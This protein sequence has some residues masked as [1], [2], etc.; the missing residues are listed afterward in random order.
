MD[1]RLSDDNVT[2]LSD[3]INGTGDGL[4]AD[5]YNNRDFTDFELARTDATVDFDWG[6]GSPDA[7]IDADTFSVRWTGQIEPRFSETYTFE[8]RSDDGVRLWVNN[9]LIIERY[10]DQAP[11]RHTGTITLEAGQRYDIRLDY[12]ENGGGATSELR[13]SS[14]SQASEIIP[15]SQLYSAAVTTPD[16]PVEPNPPMVGTGDGLR[17]DYYNNRDFTDLELTRTDATVDFDWGRGSPDA[18]IAADTYSIRWTGQVEPQFSETYTFQTSSDDGVRLWVNDKLIID[19]FVDQPSTA[20]RGTIAL[21]AGQRYDIRL[22]YYENYG[23]ASA[24][25]RWSSASQPLEIIPQSQLYSSAVT[26]P[27]PPIDPEPPAGSESISIGDPD[28][29]PVDTDVPGIEINHVYTVSENVIALRIETG[30]VARGRQV[31]YVSEAGDFIRDDGWI[32][33]DNEAIG[34]QV[35]GAPDKIRLVD[36]YVGSKLDTAWADNINNYQIVAADGSTITPTNV[37]RKSKIDDMAHTGVWEFEWPMDHIVYLELPNDL[38][39]GETYQ[40]NFGGDILEDA[41]FVYDPEITRSDAVHVSH[42]GFDPDDSAKVAFLSTWMG[43]GGGLDYDAGTPFWLIDVATGERVYEGQTTLSKAA[44]EAEDFRG[45]N[46]SQTDVFMMD[47]SDFGTPGQYAVYV[48]GVGTSYEFEIGENTWRDAFYISARGMYHQRSGIE[49]EQ[50][51]TDYARPRPFHPEDGVVIYQ[52]NVALMDTSMGLNGGVDVFEALQANRT[53]EIVTDAW[54]G[55]MDAGDWDRR[56]Q[57][58]DVSRSF[59]ELVELHGDY[60]DS[61]NLNIPES[62][63]DLPDILDEALWG[64]DVFRRL[65][66]EEGGIPGGIESAGHPIWFEGSWQESQDIMVYAPGIWSSYFYSGVAARAAHVLTDYDPALAQTYQES[67]LRAMNWANAELSKQPNDRYNEIYDQRNLAAAELYRLTGEQQWH[68]LFLETTVYTDPNVA[69]SV[70][71]SHNHIQ[72]AFVYVRT[73]RPVNQTIQENAINAMVRQADYEISNME[74]TAYRWNVNPWAPVGWGDSFGAPH[75]EVLLRTH[76][77]TGDETYLEA[78]L[79]ASQFSAGANPDN[80]SYTTGIGYQ[81]PDNP[82]I[83]DARA[84]GKSAPTG[85]TVYGPLDLQNP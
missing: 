17:A 48:D 21:E 44:N 43:D 70:W 19:K 82:L 55:W 37:Y 32:F 81:S 2:I 22:D 26:T 16:P 52:S 36:E 45:R 57:H 58:L 75:T 4:R 47:F 7:A 54:G 80:M 12:Y 72:A 3:V 71:Q 69:P 41:E 85:I 79:L 38:A 66:T 42:L 46:H 27:E 31:D 6:R 14:E 29:T 10:Y 18:A 83:G 84:L 64:L 61:V 15:Q 50:P 28:L 11:A 24:E 5:Y 73:E 60:F 35:T 56:I 59:L 9:E 20:H 63:N 67:A 49:L 77:L 78:S 62:N 34:W 33:R 1:I 74:N 23:R 25:L 68:D 39:Q 53:D 51:Y 30:E 40:L 13:W 8:T 65:Q 76:A